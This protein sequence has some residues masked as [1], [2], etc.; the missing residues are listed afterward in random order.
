LF[1]DFLKRLVQIELK[2]ENPSKVNVRQSPNFV[3]RDNEI[4]FVT[5]RG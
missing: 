1:S 2:E 4:D 5:D 3:Q